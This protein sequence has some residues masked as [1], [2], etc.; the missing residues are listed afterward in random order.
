MAIAR[1]LAADPGVILFD[2]PFGALDAIT[3][4]ELQE[5]FEE[6]RGT[7]GFTALFITH[8]L[9]EALRLGD[10]IAVMREGRVEQVASA[11]SLLSSPA[12]SYVRTLLRRAGVA[13]S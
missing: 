1:A 7:T 5:G 3:R 2:E 4:S 10:R 12:T 11:D 8:D 13:G 9:R 6:L